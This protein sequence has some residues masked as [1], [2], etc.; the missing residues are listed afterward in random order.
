MENVHKIDD[1]S[2][3]QGSSCCI[4]DELK[5]FQKLLL[6]EILV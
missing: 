5:F 4:G 2:M 1:K 6:D 3:E